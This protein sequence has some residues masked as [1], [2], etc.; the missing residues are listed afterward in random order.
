MMWVEATVGNIWTYCVEEGQQRQG[1]RIDAVEQQD[2]R[3]AMHMVHST[4]GY[5]EVRGAWIK[6]AK[7]WSQCKLSPQKIDRITWG[8]KVVL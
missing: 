3:L 8:P 5:L 4:C 1:L 2:T 7:A 6:T